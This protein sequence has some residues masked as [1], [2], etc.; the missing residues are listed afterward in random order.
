[1]AAKGLGTWI[2]RRFRAAL[3][4]LTRPVSGR[5]PREGSGCQLASANHRLL[6]YS[7][8]APNQIQCALSGAIFLPANRSGPGGRRRG[9]GM[10][11][12]PW[13]SPPQLA[14]IPQSCGANV[15][16]EARGR[17]CCPWR[18]CPSLSLLYSFCLF[19][20][21][22][23]TVPPGPLPIRDGRRFSCCSARVR[24]CPARTGNE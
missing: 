20:G 12:G 9:R 16:Q 17:F 4:R 6:Q 21:C 3:V 22:V 2:P 7:R 23:L 8:R 15:T 1:M 10:P 14:A 5:H 18:G 11:V 19:H 24:D 13:I